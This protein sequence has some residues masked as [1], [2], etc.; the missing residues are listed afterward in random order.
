MWYLINIAKK[1]AIT[2]TD[3]RSMHCLQSLFNEFCTDV[4]INHRRLQSYSWLV[5]QWAIE[6][7]AARVLKRILVHCEV[8]NNTFRHITH[9]NES[10]LQRR[11]LDFTHIGIYHLYVTNVKQWIFIHS[12]ALSHDVQKYRCMCNRLNISVQQITGIWRWQ[13]VTSNTDTLRV[14]TPGINYTYRVGRKSD[15]PFN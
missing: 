12:A 10:W 4:A 3:G 1:V 6:T 13:Y 8:K 5:L 9:I 11:F 2:C 14:T 7:S 15:T